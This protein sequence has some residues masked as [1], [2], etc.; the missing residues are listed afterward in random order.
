MIGTE[1]QIPEEEIEH[2]RTRTAG[3]IRTL[4]S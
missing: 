4:K 3:A 2:G 1:Q